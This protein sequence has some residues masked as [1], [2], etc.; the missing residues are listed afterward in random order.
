MTATYRLPDRLLLDDAVR[1]VLP[2][3]HG[4]LRGDGPGIHRE[5]DRPDELLGRKLS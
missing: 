5:P 1:Q 4:R 3:R 2:G